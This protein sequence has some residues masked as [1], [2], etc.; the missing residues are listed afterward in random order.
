MLAGTDSGSRS[1]NPILGWFTCETDEDGGGGGG[2]NADLGLL[3][4]A[5]WPCSCCCWEGGG[6][7]WGT[8][9]NGEAANGGGA[10]GGW[11]GLISGCWDGWYPLCCIWSNCC[12]NLEISSSYL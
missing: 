11:D 5:G 4:N 2:G 8:L 1:F 9:V 10:G 3:L 7:K 6:P 12:L